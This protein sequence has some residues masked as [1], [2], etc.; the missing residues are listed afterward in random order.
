MIR[1]GHRQGG[2]V[3]GGSSGVVCENLIVGSEVSEGMMTHFSNIRWSRFLRSSRQTLEPQPLHKV[4]REVL[5]N[6]EARV[7]ASLNYN[8][9]MDGLIVE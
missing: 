9:G 5:K 6:E 7:A 2:G 1:A 4:R 3:G 8:V